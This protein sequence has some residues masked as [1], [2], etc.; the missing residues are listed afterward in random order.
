MAFEIISLVNIM[1]NWCFAVAFIWYW[2]AAQ[3]C[4]YFLHW[5]FV[6]FFSLLSLLSII[7]IAAICCQAIE[8]ASDCSR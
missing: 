1:D 4:M 5:E 3:L 7:L 2:V 6:A 8:S